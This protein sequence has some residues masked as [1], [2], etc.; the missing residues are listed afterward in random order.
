[1]GD[2][3]VDHGIIQLGTAGLDVIDDLGEEG[4]AEVMDAA[5]V[6]F[7]DRHQAD[8]AAGKG[9]CPLGQDVAVFLCGFD[10]ALAGGAADAGFS[11]QRQRH[12]GRRGI[13]QFSK[14]FDR[15]CATP[16]CCL[17]DILT[18][19]GEKCNKQF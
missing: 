19:I 16:R 6:G 11:V 14:I 10:D 5:G 4:G 12:G 13:G 9:G 18:D 2:H 1:M 8:D 15:H 7:G 17:M 3:G